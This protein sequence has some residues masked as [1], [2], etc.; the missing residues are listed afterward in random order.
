MMINRSNSRDFSSIRLRAI[1]GAAAVG[2]LVAVAVLGFANLRHQTN[3]GSLVARLVS[4]EVEHRELATRLSGGFRWAPLRKAQREVELHNSDSLSWKV[5]AGGILETVRSN[6]SPENRHAGAIAQTILGRCRDA[7]ETLQRLTSSGHADAAV[8]NDLSATLYCAATR[9]DDPSQLAEALVAV[10]AALRANGAFPE[11]RFNRALI[12][13]ALGLRDEAREAWEAFLRVDGSSGWSDEAREHV[14]RLEP[15][16]PFR[17]VFERIY[18]RLLANPGEASAFARKY[19]QEARLWGETEIL[20]RWAVAEDAGDAAAAAKHLA[21]AR[22][23]GAELARNGGD[24]MLEALVAAIDRSNPARRK[25]LVAAHIAFRN[26]QKAYG[27][28]LLPDA[29]QLLERAAVK[30]EDGDSPGQL[31]A[32]YFRANTMFDQGMEKEAEKRLRRLKAAAPPAF[33]AHR[34]QVLWQ[35]GTV[36]LAQSRWGKCIDAYSESIATFEQLRE[37]NYAATVRENL[38][39]A[40]DRIGNP[41]AA[42]KHRMLALRELGRRRNGRLQLAIAS[43]GRAALM[44]EEWPVALSFLNIEIAVLQHIVDPVLHADALLRRA[45]VHVR[46]ESRV[47]GNADLAQAHLQIARLNDASLRAHMEAVAKSVEA[48]LT[49]DPATAVALLTSAIE[50]HSN[51]G[52]R[53]Y[54]PE[55]LFDRAHFFR[56]MGN[57]ARAAEDL[58]RAIAQLESDRHS[59][60]EGEDRWGFFHASKRLFAAAVD[61]ALERGQVKDALE[62]AERARARALLDTFGVSWPRVAT[63]DIPSDTAVIEYVADE[64][65]LI[66]FVLDDRGVRAIIHDVPKKTLMAE[67]HAFSQAGETGDETALRRYGRML[68][69]RL[70]EP[71]ERELVPKSRLAFV[72][73]SA[74]DPI[75]FAA[76]VDGAG[77]YLIES[78][79]VTV[80]PSAAVF[81]RLTGRPRRTDRLLLVRGAEDIGILAASRREAEKIGAL[82]QVAERLQGEAATLEAFATK[83]TEA[84]VIH[85]TGHAVASFAPGRPG[86][87][88]LRGAA[89]DGVLD[90]REIAALRLTHPSLV[91]LAACGTAAGEKRATE[92][93]ISIARAFLAAGVPSTVATLWPIADDEAAEFFPVF[94]QFLTRGLAPA[95][96]LRATQ[97]EWIHR[98]KAS[99]GLWAGVQALGD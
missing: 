48:S 8:W 5:A 49:G 95:E 19:P 1:C 88:L 89:E 93:T 98:S 28:D 32:S 40:Y 78:R 42:W 94:H 38:A 39:E 51:G 82:Y 25:A 65:R 50:F 90:S 77:R 34:A 36:Y 27:D 33:P 47:A 74:F 52:R 11:A 22:A 56:S 61:L 53:L 44:A 85:F 55:L 64:R 35:L 18:A 26:G 37:M 41:A 58:E 87:L 4:T 54:L 72:P 30:F 43:A 62:Y 83:A 9:D 99:I 63:K 67:I 75:P 70:I 66:L 91:V 29:Q 24:R 92:G 20:G 69:R 21:V 86:Y 79:A 60:S 7:A 15:V 31:L 84:D 13:E 10:D 6:P 76:L 17:E 14:A 59:L 16:A 68:Y 3:N 96:A 73:D 81:A 71:V 2:G 45:S 12:L 97:L 80:Q 57:S 23:A 46:L